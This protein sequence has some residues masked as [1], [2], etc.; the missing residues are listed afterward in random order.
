MHPLGEENFYNWIIINFS[1]SSAC[2][3]FPVRLFVSNYA[4]V[5]WFFFF[6]ASSHVAERFSIS[7]TSTDLSFVRKK[8][9]FCRF[10]I[11]TDFN[12]TKSSN[13]TIDLVNFSP[14]FQTVLSREKSRE[15]IE[16]KIMASGGLSQIKSNVVLD[17]MKSFSDT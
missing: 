5:L 6:S 9:T 3:Y 4:A 1:C 15:W 12:L 14:Q 8:S 10:L 16:N 17:V 11:S 2:G 13:L 7:L